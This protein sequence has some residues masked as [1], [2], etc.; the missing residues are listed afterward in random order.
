MGT[1]NKDAGLRGIT[2]LFNKQHVDPTMDLMG[3]ENKFFNV[4]TST[5]AGDKDE[6]D[7]N[8]NEINKLAK[9]LNIKLDDTVSNRGTTIAAKLDNLSSV[10]GGGCNDMDSVSDIP[11]PVRSAPSIS[12]KSQKPPVYIPPPPPQPVASTFM[13][14]IQK[15]SYPQHHY[16]G[17]SSASLTEEQ[18]K[19]EH[20][21]RVLGNIKGDT[22]NVFSTHIEETLDNKANKLEQIASL[23][24]SLSEEGQDLSDIPRVTI[25]SSIEEINSV[26]S[27]L[28]LKNNRYRYSTLAEEAISS[29]A[30]I[31]ESVFDGTTT[32][33]ILNIAPDYTGYSSTVHVKLH[34]LRHETSQVVASIVE[35]H[36]VS[37]TSRILMEML[38]SFV[39]YPRIK[40]KQRTS[41]SVT[42]LTNVDSRKSF[43][44]M[45]D[46][47]ETHD[48]WD[49]I[50]DL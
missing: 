18:T 23:K 32:I 11:I 7:S 43:N 45:R 25:E 42:A 27:L 50:Q 21:N 35:K 9:E 37:P 6:L 30:E 33:P 4:D 8:I 36:N 48:N 10:S 40:H 16:V 2:S 17:R 1:T 20:V 26:L 14:N 49:N 44:T 12:V 34:R 3:V 28:T 15:P 46:K 29:C 41:K 22:K 39:L 5:I 24:I 31:L 19:R 13:P 47:L 38:P